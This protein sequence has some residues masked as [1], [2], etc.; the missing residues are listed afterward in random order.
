MNLS[1]AGASSL[2]S[3]FLLL[4]ARRNKTEIAG[5]G[6]NRVDPLGYAAKYTR[7]FDAFSPMIFLLLVP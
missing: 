5:T 6:R 2:K 1:I 4:T 7:N 3:P